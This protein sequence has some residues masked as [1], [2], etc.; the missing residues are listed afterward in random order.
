MGQP[1]VSYGA[2]SEE[3]KGPQLIDMKA[4]ADQAFKAVVGPERF[5]LAQQAS[6]PVDNED[7]DEYDEESD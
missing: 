2:E 4:N 7:E 6:E 5:A 3:A 1:H